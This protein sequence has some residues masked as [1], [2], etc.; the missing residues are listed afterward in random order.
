MSTNNTT[1]A[2]S[3]QAARR[4]TDRA[5]NILFHD[6]TD[7]IFLII[8]EDRPLNRDYL[9]AVNAHGLNTMNKIIG[10]YIKDRL[11]LLNKRQSEKPKSKH[12]LSYREHALR[13]ME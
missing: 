4:I 13:P 11:D 7:R 2:P 10:E 5:L 12:I 6:I 9:S 1:P 8:E 3:T